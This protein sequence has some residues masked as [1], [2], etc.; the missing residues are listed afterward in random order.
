MEA[1]VTPP[2]VINISEKF[3]QI[4]E[5][6]CPHVIAS[7]NGQHV[8]IGRLKGEFVWHKH[9]DEDE[10]FLVIEGRL[11]LRFREGDRTL[12]PGEIIVVPRG[13]EHCPVCESEVRVLLFEPAATINTGSTESG[14]RRDELPGI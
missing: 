1:Y 9:D 4:G 8:R 6:W 7:L 11:T 14:L 5:F 13:T 2:E 12:G 3:D 10:M